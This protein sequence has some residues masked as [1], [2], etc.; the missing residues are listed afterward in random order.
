[1]TAL[2]DIV[3]K[4]NDNT[5]NVTYTAVKPAGGDGDP[6]MWRDNSPSGYPGQKPTLLVSSQYNGNR[7]ARRVKLTFKMN[8]LF[9]N[10]TTGVVGVRTTA[11][12]DVTVTLPLDMS[13]STALEFSAQFG[14][15]LASTLLRNVNTDG[16]AP[17]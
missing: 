10:S 5:T 3:V 9:T 6:A 2:A 12:A 1:M 13:S 14:N 11:I 8:D 7:T 4:K 16:F 15:L 17:V